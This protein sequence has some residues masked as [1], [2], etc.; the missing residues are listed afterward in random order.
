MADWY[1]NFGN[2][3][4]T[5]YYAVAQW[6]AAT[7]YAAGAIVRQLATPTVGNERC[8]RTAAGGTSGGAEPSWNL[9]AGGTTTDNTVTWTEVTGNAT[10]NWSAPAARI[11]TIL[12]SRAGAGDRVFVGDNHAE[13]QASNI[14]W[15]GG[16]SYNAAP[17]KT[18][19]VLHTS[20]APPSASDL[21]TTATATASGALFTFNTFNYFYGIS[22]SGSSGINFSGS[23]NEN[24][25]ENC[26]L[27][28]SAS[29]TISSSTHSVATFINCSWS[30]TS[31][32]LTL[33]LGNART[34]FRNCTMFTGGTY[35]TNALDFSLTNAEHYA[36]FDGCDFSMLT[37]NIIS[38]WGGGEPQVNFI[39]CKFNASA[40]IAPNALG[41]GTQVNLINCSGT[42]LQRLVFAGTQ[43]LETTYTRSGGASTPAGTAFS[44][45]I[46][47]N[48][49]ATAV[50]PFVS[51]PIPIWNATTGS[52]ITA[53][54]E[55]ENGGTTLTNEDIWVLFEYLGDATYQ[56][57]SAQSSGL[58]SIASTLVSSATNLTTSSATWNGALGSAVKQYM[59]ASFTPQQAGLYRA[60]IYVA[61]ASL[62]VYVDPYITQ[63]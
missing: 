43:S 57:S 45:K 25:L 13:T 23:S 30:F 10:Y 59:Q 12:T 53:T 16:A 63:A 39:N 33:Y 51:L 14:T 18:I 46:V 17:C 42:A 8:F 34:S 22:V 37:G 11:A 40:T 24:T 55:I 7:V 26:T 9:A 19:C 61:K 4:S 15:G 50:N 49:S 3:S 1:V 54:I 52:A 2:G 62:T 28:A 36:T 60:Y 44:W 58:S 27:T 20:S 41:N 35:P 47:T 31:T 48:A 6:A 5:G 56:I 38:N 21:R 29:P 32:G